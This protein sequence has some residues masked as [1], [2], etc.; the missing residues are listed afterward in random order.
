[1]DQDLKSLE[2]R[3]KGLRRENADHRQ[4]IP[5]LP[6]RE[7]FSKDA[8]WKALHDSGIKRYQLDEMVDRILKDG[9]KIFAILV[10]THQAGL[11]PRFIEEAEFHDQ[12]LP[13]SL[14]ILEKQLS[15]PSA[16]DF[17]EKQWELI[18]PT[19]YR[20]TIH[21]SLNSRFIL[22]FVL[23]QRIGSGAFGT[24]YEIELDHDHQQLD[25][26]FQGRLVR[27]EL[28]NIEDHEIELQN[29]AILSHLRH[30]N[31]LGLLASYTYKGKHN[32]VAP[33]AE[34]GTLADLFT[35]DRQMTSFKS[36]QTFFIALARLSSAVGHVHSFV[37]QRID[38]NLIGCHHDLRPKNILVSG[39]TLMLADFGLAR[40][41]GQS[42]S[43][44][45]I[46]KQ[47]GG[48]YRAPECEDIDDD[49]FPKF[50]VRR[51]SDIWSLGCIIAEVTTYMISGRP[52]I[53]E[54]KKK[55]RFKKGMGW[56]YLFH[57]GCR[58][59]N[60]AV[61]D[62][63]SDLTLRSSTSCNMLVGL[64]R[65]MLCMDEKKRPKAR[66]VTARLQL[67]ALYEVADEVDQLFSTVPLSNSLDA[68][69]EQKRFEAWKYAMG[70]FDPAFK[71]DIERDPDQEQDSH[72]DSIL[73]SLW[74]I[75]DY[76]NSITKRTQSVRQWTYFPLGGFNDR[77]TEL[78]DAR[79]QE[80]SRTYFRTS[81]IES[82]DDEFIQK[83]QCDVKGMP[84]DKEIRMRANLKHMTKL[85]MEHQERDTYKQQLDQKAIKIGPKLGYHNLGSAREGDLYHPVLVEWRPYGRK[86]A[87]NTINDEYFVRVEAIAELLSQDK[88]EEFRA[89]DCRGFFHDPMQLAFGIVYNCP[90]PT[91]LGTR[92][93]NPETLHN[94]IGRAKGIAN[95]FPALNDRLRLAY[96]LARSVLE[97]HLVGWLHKGLTSSN[98]AFFAEQ[99]P[100]DELSLREPYILG[101]SHSRPDETSAFTAGPTESGAERYQHPAYLRESQ[102]YRAEFD[103]YSLGIILLEI[104]LW[105]PLDNMTRKYEGSHEDIRE[106]LLRKRIPLLKQSM[107]RRYCE[108]ARVCLESDFGESDFRGGHTDKTKSLH[109]SF[110]R[111]V[112]SQLSEISF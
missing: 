80:K 1:M 111:L 49:L 112:V 99:E 98:V 81:M 104:G 59:P 33:L 39:E 37:E 11:T 85:A 10:L 108:A 34:G 72:F 30:P 77:L 54:F 94:L 44:G 73:D 43:S 69:I 78:L 3:I 76:L 56:Y 101:F 100:S 18:A 70:F 83:I 62:W 65:R 36:N 7:V 92:N 45:T 22:P 95:F 57:C 103:Y 35:N 53:E 27:K 24:V 87:N 97:F 96:T 66:E 28:E 86:F 71:L 23:D 58:E 16:K 14:E 31:I 8:I 17:Y 13:F 84:F 91:G 21:K 41:K 88:P 89:L 40:F 48:D 12:R 15:L 6:L 2:L 105:L 20:G 109:L 26:L 90:L 50:V 29:L 5:Q 93:S 52:G 42:E 19:F 60:K 46:F 82:E 32:L 79:S 38:L 107:G 67:I 110:E 75:R 68:L 9:I 47:G 25:D 51:S 61:S 4:F 64:A 63:L 106:M 102:R 74:K 55:R